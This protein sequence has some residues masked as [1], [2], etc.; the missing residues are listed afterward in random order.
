ME[1]ALK[2]VQALR[3]IDMAITGSLDLRVTF[4]A[5]L[6]E[7]TSLLNVDGAAILRLDPN[8]ATLN[9]E[10]WRMKEKIGLIF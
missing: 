9:Y 5:I 8:T 6:D 10:A 7:V 2:Q 1:L 3:N 4:K